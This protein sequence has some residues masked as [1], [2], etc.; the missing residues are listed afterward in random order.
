MYVKV[1][2]LFCMRSLKNSAEVPCPPR[3]GLR[4]ALGFC[5]VV[6]ESVIEVPSQSRVMD[7]LA[8]G[9]VK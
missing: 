6:V 8:V 4:F 7:E 9:E 5:N 1:V 2:I 3:E